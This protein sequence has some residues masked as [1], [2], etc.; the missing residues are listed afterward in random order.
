MS[1]EL[2][3]RAYRR[4]F[5]SDMHT[6]K[7]MCWDAEPRRRPN[8]GHVV[9][10][11]ASRMK[12]DTVL[13]KGPGKMTDRPESSSS[14][15]V[16]SGMSNL[17][18]SNSV[19][20][21]AT[22]RS[23]SSLLSGSPV[24]IA[25]HADN[26]TTHEQNYFWSGQVF[27]EPIPIE[28]DRKPVEKQANIGVLKKMSTLSMHN[29][30]NASEQTIHLGP[31]STFSSDSSEESHLGQRENTAYE[32]MPKL[33]PAS[34]TSSKRRGK[35]HFD[36]IMSRMTVDGQ[37]NPR[38]AGVASMESIRGITR[39]PRRLNQVAAIE[40]LVEH[41]TSF[42]ADTTH[43]YLSQRLESNPGIVG[44]RLGAFLSSVFEDSLTLRLVNYQFRN[45][46][47]ASSNVSAI[48]FTRIALLCQEAAKQFSSVYPEYICHLPEVQRIIG[49]EEDSNDR[50]SAIL[51]EKQ[52]GGKI[53][54]KAL[55]DFL[56]A[57]VTHLDRHH[58]T[59][60][61]IISEMDSDPEAPV[62]QEAYQEMVKT[63]NL[64]HLSSWQQSEDEKGWKDFVSAETVKSAS[65]AD[66]SRQMLLFE[67][68]SKERD[69]VIKLKVLQKLLRII[70][71]EI[72]G[73]RRKEDTSLQTIFRS[74][75][76]A[77]DDFLRFHQQLLENFFTLQ[78]GQHP[79]IGPIVAKCGIDQIPWHSLYDHRFG[80]SYRKLVDLMQEGK[81]RSGIF[82]RIMQQEPSLHDESDF[83]SFLRTPSSH[84][85]YF[86]DSLRA[87]S[88]LL[89]E[90]S[91]DQQVISD[92]FPRLWD[93]SLQVGL[94]TSASK[95]RARLS[96]L[97]A[98]LD[99]SSYPGME[100][101]IDITSTSRAVIMSGNLHL[102]VASPQS[103]RMSLNERFALLLDNYLLFATKTNTQGY[104]RLSVC[105]RP[106]P[107]DLISL[108]VDNIPPTA[109]S[110]ALFPCV[111]L[112]YI[113]QNPIFLYGETEYATR[114][115]CNK[116]QESQTA[117]RAEAMKTKVIDMETVHT[118][119]K[120]L[121][122]SAE[123][124][125]ADQTVLAIAHSGREGGI[126]LRQ[127]SDPNLRHV[128]ALNG[129]TDL[130]VMSEVGILM[131]LVEKS[132]FWYR[133]ENLMKGNHISQRSVDESMAVDFYRA[134]NLGNRT[135]LVV[136]AK[137]KEKT[138]LRFFEVIET[139]SSS[140]MLKV[141]RGK[142]GPF[143]LITEVE[144][145]YLIKDVYF[146]KNSFVLVTNT[147]YRVKFED[148]QQLKESLLSTRLQT[149]PL[150]DD[151]L[152][153]LAERCRSS[154]PL[155][156]HKFN[157]DFILC[158]KDFA[159]Y[160][161]VNGQLSSK[162]VEWESRN[163]QNVIFRSPY[164]LILGVATV[165]VRQIATGKL[166]QLLAIPGHMRLSWERRQNE[167][168]TLDLS[169]HLLTSTDP[170][171]A[172]SDQWYALDNN[173]PY[174]LYRLLCR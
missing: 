16:I 44:A 131:V 84:L 53:L 15:S 61:Y 126:W 2:K 3:A 51:K 128:V 22:P 140:K 64:A 38:W 68:I 155:A 62:L 103:G 17:S 111:K 79:W 164:M 98:A 100:Y 148:A 112:H 12:A 63:V 71:W 39:S 130:T 85:R 94:K 74:L 56:R 165:E 88:D 32:R 99:F 86:A 158:Y 168:K 139:G 31:Q 11:I 28:L 67:L 171:N 26:T 169:V 20:H 144:L 42:L 123:F 25:A 57:P 76:A 160:I 24:S 13:E 121:L 143:N 73:L 52:P 129:I 46:L 114:I 70:L 102:G 115:W 141:F 29:Q 104:L 41:E 133:L 146:L 83:M 108:S 124:S 8:T 137:K 36:I 138:L 1:S 162:F 159:S 27:S 80:T 156:I 78:R 161:N 95:E 43:E 125:Y 118:S 106:L 174:N 14:S 154:T 120:P 157:D 110:D 58:R 18:T 54:R 167:S 10:V 113:G 72:E 172:T 60:Q 91:E 81:V 35:D 149:L 173:N 142:F 4:G 33:K 93:V 47:Q 116:L 117:R 90:G 132:L 82:K 40:N 166:E 21:P 96:S 6:L 145:T 66:V 7:K 109:P 150:P 151:P 92:M 135:F 77:F 89:T 97:S 48:G 5:S 65:K 87:L 75:I 69:Y 50:F 23:A 101:D 105:E 153:D 134:G 127:G 45:A 152:A 107:L 55:D 170:D 147:F 163:A 122:C 59:L 37:V 9:Q 34:L 136:S 119:Q 19:T 49:D 30:Q